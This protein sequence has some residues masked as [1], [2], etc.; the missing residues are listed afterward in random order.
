MPLKNLHVTPPGGFQFRQPQT[1]WTAPTP[2]GS[3]FDQTVELIIR[4]RLNNP[5]FNLSTDWE[6]VSQELETFT[7]AR[8]GN[9]PHWCMGS[10]IAQK[11]TL[12]VPVRAGARSGVGAVLA[13]ARKL[14]V[15]PAVI[16]DWL[17]EGGKP[18]SQEV[19]QE[20]AN[21]C[22]QCPKNTLGNFVV[23]K[24]TKAVSDTIKK[25]LEAKH[26]M[27]LTVKG[28]EDLHVCS[29]C[30]CQLSL[31]VHTPLKIVKE[32]TSD[33]V[34]NDLADVDNG[35]PVTCWIKQGIG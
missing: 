27:N 19:S 21:I 11:K 14:S 1:G 13:D 34:W 5:R 18:V 25:Q 3:T 23:S 30:L 6:E 17:G 4:H 20:R 29:A 9:D 26:K 16:H 22:L 8:L 7:C 15:A 10:S 12:P 33:E 28:E 32:H 35:D 24:I 31:K 2:L